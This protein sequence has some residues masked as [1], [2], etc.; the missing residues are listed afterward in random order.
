MG[1]SI[2]QALSVTISISRKQYNTFLFLFQ[3]L[4]LRLGQKNNEVYLQIYYLQLE[5]T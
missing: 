4:I 3:H 5:L 2:Y 1:I